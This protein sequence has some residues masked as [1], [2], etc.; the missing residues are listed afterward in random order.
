MHFGAVWGNPPGEPQLTSDLFIVLEGYK[1]ECC[2]GDAKTQWLKGES[3]QHVPT[4][5]CKCNVGTGAQAPTLL[6]LCPPWS[7]AESYWWNNALA[8]HVHAR[9]HSKRFIAVTLLDSSISVLQKT[10]RLNH[11]LH[12]LCSWQPYPSVRCAGWGRSSACPPLFKDTRQTPL[13]RWPP[14]ATW[15]QGRLR[16]AVFG[17]AGMGNVSSEISTPLPGMALPI[18]LS[19]FRLR[20]PSF[21]TQFSSS[22]LGR[23]SHSPHWLG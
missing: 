18:F 7:A 10:Q 8:A 22:S 20:L 2:I 1:L 16:N 14:L 5:R 17:W 4:Y 12:H 9:P 6:L 19:W 11:Q 23:H 15:L 21:K 3:S 13:V